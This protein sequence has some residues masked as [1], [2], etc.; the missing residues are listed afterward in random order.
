M[1][2]VAGARG[3]ASKGKCGW[4]GGGGEAAEAEVVLYPKGEEG[5][6]VGCTRR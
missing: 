2:D 3:Q 1:E 4:G 6:G 5:E